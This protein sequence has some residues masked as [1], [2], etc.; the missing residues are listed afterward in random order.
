MGGGGIENSP[1]GEMTKREAEE[2]G[3]G[4]FGRG[5]A[6]KVVSHFT[7]SPEQEHVTRVKEDRS[8]GRIV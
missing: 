3:W 6:L 5:Q 1:S 4:R 2:R 7:L 8:G